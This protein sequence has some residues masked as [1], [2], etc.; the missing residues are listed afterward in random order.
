MELD[1]VK[2]KGAQLSMWAHMA[3]VGADGKPDV[4]PVHPCWEGDTIWIMGGIDSVK[5][6]NIGHQPKVAMHWPVYGWGLI[7]ECIW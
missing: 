4:T 1:D 6:R 7:S 3:T 5:A 2:A